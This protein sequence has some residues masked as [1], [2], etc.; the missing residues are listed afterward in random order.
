MRSGVEKQPRETVADY[1]TGWT[2]R[3]GGRMAF[4]IERA[5]PLALR[6]SRTFDYEQPRM[7]LHVGSRVAGWIGC[8]VFCSTALAD[9]VDRWT[10]RTSGGT[11][12]L[13]GVTF[14]NGLF[15]AVGSVGTILTSTNGSNWTK[16]TSGT[17][18]YL[19]EVAFGN[20]IWV[21]V[22]AQG[23]VVTSVNGTNGWTTRMSGTAGYIADIAFGNGVFAAVVQDGPILVSADGI[24]WTNRGFS[25][26]IV[27]DLAFANGTFLGG[28]IAGVL[29]STN[30]LTWTNYPLPFPGQIAAFAFGNGK[31]AGPGFT[32]SGGVMPIIANSAAGTNWAV[33]ASGLP[34]VTYRAAFGNGYFITAGDPGGFLASHDGQNWVM[35][36]ITNRAF[37]D[38]MTFG[39][40]T[41]VAVGSGGTIV[42]SDDLSGPALTGSKVTNGF[43]VVIAGALGQR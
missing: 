10:T 29:A 34:L 32:F 27:N 39:R 6:C 40:N 37:F 5:V 33:A 41:F 17:T 24:N 30:G 20:N 12:D 23:A 22:G 38:G 4:R 21:A 36:G 25:G 35:H 15:V 11:N 7:K 28:G 1:L 2:Q 13:G 42:Q 8:F 26:Q 16:R 19:D 9:P 43:Q 14:A 18:R 3:N 31:Y